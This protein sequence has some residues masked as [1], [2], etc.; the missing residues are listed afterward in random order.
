MGIE[1]TSP[2]WK[3]GA[4]PLCY[5]RAPAIGVPM[6]APPTYTSDR[7]G[8]KA[9]PAATADRGRLLHAA[10]RHHGVR[11]AVQNLFVG[12]TNGG[13]NAAESGVVA[14]HEVVRT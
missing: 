6:N 2:A 14:H 8:V 3:A 5:A 12:G 10:R 4:L 13:Q 9:K 7:L 1:P 11:H